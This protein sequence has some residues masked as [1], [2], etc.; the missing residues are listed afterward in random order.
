MRKR[1]RASTERLLAQKA[2]VLHD[3]ATRALPSHEAHRT[4]RLHDGVPVM[5]ICV[6]PTS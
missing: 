6:A 4:L 2:L 1:Q 3:A 5:L